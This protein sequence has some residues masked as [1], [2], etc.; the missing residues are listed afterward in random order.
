ME[1]NLTTSKSII[2]SCRNAL[3][4]ARSKRTEKKSITVYVP[5]FLVNN[6]SSSSSPNSVSSLN[7]EDTDND[8]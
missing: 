3:S 4:L 5:R 8:E 1:Q 7:A 2:K 6:S